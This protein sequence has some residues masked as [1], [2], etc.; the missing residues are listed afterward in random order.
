MELIYTRHGY[1]TVRRPGGTGPVFVE[2][3]HCDSF[4]ERAAWMEV[5][6]ADFRVTGARWAEYRRQ[7]GPPER[8]VR[9]VP[10]LVGVEAYFDCGRAINQAFSEDPSGEIAELF[11]EG[12]KVLIQA[13]PLLFEER[14]FASLDEYQRR[15]W[16]TIAGSCFYLAHPDC[17]PQTVRD[18]FQFHHRKENLF[19]RHR[20]VLVYDEGSEYRIQATLVDGWHE[21][22]ADLSARKEGFEITRARG[23]FVRGPDRLCF[24]SGDLLG[25]IVGQRLAPD[26]SR[27]LLKACAGGCAH[28]ADLTREALRALHC[29]WVQRGRG[30]RWPERGV[31]GDI[32]LQK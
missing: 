7:E 1:A 29:D 6:P 2:V 11:K 24:P 5:A 23:R 32:R 9:E 3:D 25:G 17:N 12:V 30:A 10:E 18:K 22:Q 15:L 21:I 16:E 19:S 14:G 28:L 4:C 27:N 13:E 8:A 26:N 31:G 20:S